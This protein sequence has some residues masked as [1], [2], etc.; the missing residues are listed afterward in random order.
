LGCFIFF[1]APYLSNLSLESSLKI[2]GKGT[3]GSERQYA[4][5][6]GRKVQQNK[7]EATCGPEREAK[8]N[9]G[10]DPK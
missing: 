1:R 3:S 9:L 7:G 5:L 6:S 2:Q 10:R 4:L 8:H